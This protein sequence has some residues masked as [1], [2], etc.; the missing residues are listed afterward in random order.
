MREPELSQRRLNLASLHSLLT[1]LVSNRRSPDL[2][3]R[4]PFP[5]TLDMITLLSIFDYFNE[6]VSMTSF[7][8]G[9]IYAFQ[10]LK[11]QIS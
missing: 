8:F 6:A 11:C 9:V 10:Y 4:N 7:T 1:G 2:A 3:G 5:A